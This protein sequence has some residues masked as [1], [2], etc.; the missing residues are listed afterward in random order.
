MNPSIS[1]IGL[2]GV[3]AVKSRALILT[4]SVMLMVLASS[5]NLD[6]TR[7]FVLKKVLVKPWI[8]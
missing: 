4:E 1:S 3:D 5:F 7:R 6:K 8:L 2:L